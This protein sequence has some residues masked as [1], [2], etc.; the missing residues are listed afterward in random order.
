MKT[1]L[2]NY[3]VKKMTDNI[4]TE[5]LDIIQNSNWMDTASKV[6]AL[7]KADYINKQVGYPDSFDKPGYI[8][9]HN[10]VNFFRIQF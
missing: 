9:T 6:K 8:E 3:K 7:Q 1:S 5:M 4:L 2:L 10:N